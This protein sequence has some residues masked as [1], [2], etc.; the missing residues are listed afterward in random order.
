MAILIETKNLKTLFP[1]TTG[2]FRKVVGNVRAVDGINLQI[3]RGEWFGLVG[4]SG[5]GKTTLGKTILRLLKPTSG[6]IYMEMPE[7]V[8]SIIN[9]LEYNNSQSSE[10]VDLNEKY[11]LS[12]YSGKQLKSLRR[13][14]QFVYQDPFT[15]LDPR[16]KVRDTLL[17][18]ILV[19]KLMKRTGALLR[20]EE[21]MNLVGL[22]TNQLS[23]YPH[24]FSGGQRQRIAIARAL[25]TNPEF[26]VFDEPTSAL[27]VSVQAQILLLLKKLLKERNLT[28]FYIT[29]D[30]A[31]AECICSRIAVMYLGKIVETGNPNEIFNSPKHPYTLA[32]VQAIPIPDP[33]WRRRRKILS[34]EAPSP[35]NP[36]LGCRFHPRCGRTTEHCK[37][38][39]PLLQTIDNNRM[40]ACWNSLS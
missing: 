35:S 2:L 5:C 32:L 20:A 39:E 8:R 27:D 29:H 7:K 24:Q 13:R 36:P 10:L 21:L 3:E 23:R 18:P 37:L 33:T 12:L 14:M 11:D 28:Y 1:I 4:E 6:H 30:L 15:S 40:V 22:N 16:M 19:H 26:I 31:V 34:S 25:A 9:S 38:E 17:E